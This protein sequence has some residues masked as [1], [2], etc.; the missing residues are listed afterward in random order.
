MRMGGDYFSPPVSV[1]FTSGFLTSGAGAAAGVFVA[2]GPV[3]LLLVGPT[4]L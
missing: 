4:G 1:F 2:L 3:A